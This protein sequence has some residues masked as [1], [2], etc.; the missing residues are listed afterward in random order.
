[1]QQRGLK[2]LSYY[3]AIEAVYNYVRDEIKFGY[4]KDDTLS[5][6]QV[7]ADGYGQ[8]NTKG[9]LLM[10]LLRGVGIPARFHGFTIFNELQ[11]GA[12]P[13]YLFIFAP[14]RIIHSWVEV[15]FD[16]HWLDLEGYIIDKSYLSKVQERFSDQCDAFSAYGIATKCLK[17]PQ[18]D[19]SGSSTYIQKEG[20][21]DDFGIYD[22]PDEFYAEKGSNLTG[23]KRILFR[24]VLRH[25]MNFNVA[26]IRRQGIV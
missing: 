25:L 20:I 23:F 12:I 22:Q 10:A 13:N 24:Y 9:T 7:L 11:K 4:N 2:Y 18:N 17:K 14:R 1:M 3:H 8:C 16:D 19:W 15:Y 5:A 21:A 6:S 26:K